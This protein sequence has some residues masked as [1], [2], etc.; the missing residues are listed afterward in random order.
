MSSK[1]CNDVKRIMT[2]DEAI[3]MVRLQAEV[4]LRVKNQAAELSAI[5]VAPEQIY[6]M[7]RTV[8]DG[9]VE[10]DVIRVWLV[11]RENSGGGYS[12]VMRSDGAAFGLA[13]PG[14]PSDKHLVLC[15]WYRDL[16]SA[17]ASM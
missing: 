13:S 6:V 5:L 8:R 2:H 9:E 7:A 12:I 14:F 4:A 11:A 17:F 16:V 3:E 10:E 15:G 1:A